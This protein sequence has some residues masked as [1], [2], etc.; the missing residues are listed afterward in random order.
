MLGRLGERKGVYD[1]IDAVEIAVRKNPELKVCIAGDGEVEKVRTLVAKKGLERHIH[2]P[3]WIG[4]A[5]KLE[6]L[7]NA[8]AL[9]LP[10]YNEGLPIA[11]LEGMAA[12]KAILSTTVGAIPEVV[13]PENGIL[14]AP[15]DIASLAEGLL[16]LSSDEEM[17]ARMSRNNIEKAEN[18]FSIRQ[19]HEQL[20]E[21][22]R[23]VQG[24]GTDISIK[25]EVNRQSESGKTD[26]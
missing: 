22:Y 12:G 6:Y 24:L 15:G 11:I 13:A 18:L 2:V 10:S 20:A 3:G 1:L 7:K 16:R 21:Y 19:M 14:T 8:A 23:Q 17:L 4:E 26:D 5:D 25:R 9:I